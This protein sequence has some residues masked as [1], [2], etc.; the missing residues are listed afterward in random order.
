MLA[1]RPGLW[2][3]ALESYLKSLPQLD[4]SFAP[5]DWREVLALLRRS[6]NRTLVLE[7]A[8]CGSNAATMLAALKADFPALNLIVIADSP[9]ER[10]AVLNAGIDR[11]LLKSLLPDP[12]DPAFFTL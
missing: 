3:N 5:S 2:R 12:L 10:Q 9:G 4:V 11:V 6:P 7:A 1:I 8:L